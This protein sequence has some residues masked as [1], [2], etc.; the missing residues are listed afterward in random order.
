MGIR[1]LLTMPAVA[2]LVLAGAAGGAAAADPVL[3]PAESMLQLSV[4]EAGT[5]SSMD[6][7]TLM[8]GPAGGAHPEAEQACQDLAVAGGDLDAIPPVLMMCP[9]IYAPVT[10]VAIGHWQGDAVTWQRTFGNDCELMVATGA[11][12][13]F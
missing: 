5:A 8:C 11:V 7:T 13:N 6:A 3:L 2:A 1:R 12:F 4:M 10:A 9:M